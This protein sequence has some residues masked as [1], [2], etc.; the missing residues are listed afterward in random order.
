MK[1]E[2]IGL[3]RY[4]PI[5]KKAYRLLPGLPWAP[6]KTLKPPYPLKLLCYGTSQTCD[7]LKAFAFLEVWNPENGC[8]FQPILPWADGKTLQLCRS[9]V[10]SSFQVLF[11]QVGH[12]WSNLDFCECKLHLDGVFIFGITLFYSMLGLVA[13]KSCNL[14]VSC[15][16]RVLQLVGYRLYVR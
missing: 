10:S 13:G 5:R 1:I 11:G 2:Y 7:S 16:F 3:Y 15:N 6:L 9:S 12:W 4:R 14:W 8:P